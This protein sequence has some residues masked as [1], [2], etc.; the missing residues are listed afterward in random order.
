MKFS[1]FLDEAKFVHDHPNL[2]SLQINQ[3]VESIPFSKFY[4]I[5]HQGRL[6]NTKIQGHVYWDGGKGNENVTL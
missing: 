1:P 6:L 3:I 5:E 4:H 2:V